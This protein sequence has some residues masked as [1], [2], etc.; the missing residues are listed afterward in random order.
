MNQAQSIALSRALAAVSWADGV[1]QRSERSYLT[2]VAYRLGLSPEVFRTHVEPLLDHPIPYDRALG[3]IGE[4][5]RVI[6]SDDDR[7]LFLRELRGL[8]EADGEVAEDEQAV[9]DE[10]ESALADYGA[11]DFAIGK[12]RAVVGALWSRQRQP[13]ERPTGGGRFNGDLGAYGKNSLLLHLA[14][15]MSAG[16]HECAADP[17]DLNDVTLRAAMLARAVEASDRG[18]TPDR[19]RQSREALA[20]HLA[21]AHV[22]RFL[23]DILAEGHDYGMDRQRVCAEWNRVSTMEE[24]QDWVTELL[25]FAEVTGL[26]GD[27]VAG[28]IRLIANFLWIPAAEF[29]ALKAEEG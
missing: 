27:D 17:A 5:M 15:V 22:L 7:Q 6:S 18:W 24:R 11:L 21:D 1:L 19:R 14:D 8:F 16:G 23:V 28:E 25:R 10:V 3:V 9:L 4:L 20:P 12:F 26:N 2:A 29:H 13:I